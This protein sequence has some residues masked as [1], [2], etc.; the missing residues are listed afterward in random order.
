MDPREPPGNDP[1]GGRVREPLGLDPGAAP[2]RFPRL[3]APR[4]VRRVAPQ[5]LALAAVGLL[6]LLVLASTLWRWAA[7]ALRDQ[8]AYRLT[9]RDVTLEPDVPAWFRGGRDAFLD[10]VARDSGEHAD[11]STLDP[12]LARRLSSAFKQSPWIESVGPVVVGVN[13]KAAIHLVYREPVA[14]ARFEDRQ[15]YVVDGHG[16]IL[17][18]ADLNRDDV[19][20]LVTLLRFPAPV[21][22]R[23]GE[24]W[25]RTDPTSGVPKPDPTLAAAARVAAL[26]K[27]RPITLATDEGRTPFVVIFAI[28]DKVGLLNDDW[29]YLQVGM[30][31]FTWQIAPDPSQDEKRWTQIQDWIQRH[32]SEVHSEEKPVYEF[33]PNG[34]RP[35]EG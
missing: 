7:T 32:P 31:I 5:R 12:E 22:P 13:P 26:Q 23:E 17:R 25:M 34:I 30:L 11:L 10:G 6:G 24:S 33:G 15:V 4:A 35:I 18:A 9:L 3:I 29:L 16:V 28:K 19:E 21:E 8:P 27:V 20:R 1:T 14:F 2:R